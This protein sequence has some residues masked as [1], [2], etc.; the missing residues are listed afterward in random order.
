VR[1]R[2]S[3]AVNAS[4]V[5]LNDCTEPI[6]AQQAIQFGKNELCIVEVSASANQ[7]F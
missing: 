4:S 3:N 2:A 5:T 6:D 1:P 7:N